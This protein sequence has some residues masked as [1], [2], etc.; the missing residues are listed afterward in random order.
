MEVRNLL[1]KIKWHSD[2]DFDNI[3]IYYMSRGGE[4]G[5]AAVSGGEVKELGKHFFATSE[6]MIPYHRIKKVEYGEEV[7]FE[8]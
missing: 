7:L 8:A 1:N 2:Y 5:I 6:G 4:G 3:K